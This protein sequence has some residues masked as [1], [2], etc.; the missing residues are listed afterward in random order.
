L[1]IFFLSGISEVKRVISLYFCHM[2]RHSYGCLA[3]PGFMLLIR[4]TSLDSFSCDFLLSPSRFWGAFVLMHRTWASLVIDTM[5]VCK[6]T[7][8]CLVL[9]SALSLPLLPPP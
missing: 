9:A 6:V 1:E 4:G 2:G 7:E 3:L 8:G 5:N